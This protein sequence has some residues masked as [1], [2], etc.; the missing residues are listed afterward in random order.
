MPNIV[1]LHKD[2]QSTAARQPRLDYADPLSVRK[3]MRRNIAVAEAAGFWKRHDT[4]VD[5][6]DRR[7]PTIEV[8]VRVYEKK[9]NAHVGPAILFLHGGGFVTG[10]LDIEHPR[11]IEMCRV[12]GVTVISVDYRLAPE[13][14]FPAG[15]DDCASV[16]NWILESGSQWGID[17]SRV[18]I[19]G[20]SAG[21]CLAMAVVL[22]RRDLGREMPCFQLLIYPV[23]DDR[24]STASMRDCINTPVWDRHNSQEMWKHYLGAQYDETAALTYA[25]PARATSLRGLPPTYLVTAEHDPL[26]DEALIFAQRLLAEGV[27]TEIHQFPGAFHGFDTLGN[28]G[29]SRRARYEQYFVLQE[30]LGVLSDLSPEPQN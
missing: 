2:L 11:C 14:P 25:A 27:S 3:T 13:H 8:L 6:I 5:W 9:T 22:R 19:A 29:P 12:T 21:G 20:C 18:A 16:V 28:F 26:R 23:L 15:F 10:D 4:D 24:M 30:A 7:I 17:P 1:K